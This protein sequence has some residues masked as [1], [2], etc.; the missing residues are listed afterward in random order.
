MLNNAFRVHDLAAKLDEG[1]SERQRPQPRKNLSSE[2]CLLSRLPSSSFMDREG[3]RNAPKELMKQLRRES[4]PP[5]SPPV[6]TDAP[7]FDRERRTRTDSTTSEGSSSRRGWFS[8]KIKRSS[9]G[10]WKEPESYEIFRAIEKK[11]IMFL[12]EIRDRAFHLLLK[13]TGDA[14]PLVH[15]MRIGESHREVTIVLLGALSR[16]VNHLE[17]SDMADRRTKPLLKALRTNLKLAIDYGLQSAHT[18]LIASF[19]QTLIMS[20]G[21]KWVAGQIQNVAF[22]L[23]AGTAGKPVHMAETAVRS[24]ATKELGKA[25]LIA[26]LEDYI[27]NATADLLVMATW[28]CVSES[29]H[30]EAIPTYYFARDDRVFKAFQERLHR[31]RADLGDVTKRLKWQIRVLVRALDGRTTTYR[32]KIELLTEELDEGPGV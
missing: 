29:V 31:H 27:S 26:A 4:L 7:S 5:L 23:R 12:M 8:S 14:T 10:P 22:A 6:E 16:W 13:K 3:G 1:P 18:D 28:T 15:A 11:D 17:D 2:V 32:S 9:V 21:D 25:E 24:F 30:G 19:M 20:E